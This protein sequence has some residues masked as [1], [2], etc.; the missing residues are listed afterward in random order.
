VQIFLSDYANYRASNIFLPVSSQVPKDSNLSLGRTFGDT[1]KHFL[2]IVLQMC[3]HKIKKYSEVLI[4]P[5]VDIYVGK[6]DKIVNANI[7][8]LQFSWFFKFDQKKFL[9]RYP[10]TRSVTVIIMMLKGHIV[11]PFLYH[12]GK[13]QF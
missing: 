12:V 10:G 7:H 4:N 5:Y 1:P 2:P 8:P 11:S 6:W 13:N 3:V 9:V